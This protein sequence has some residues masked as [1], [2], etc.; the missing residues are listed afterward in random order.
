MA[1]AD[2]DLVPRPGLPRAVEALLAAAGLV[3]VLPI[4]AVAALAIVL[5]SA[6]SPLF[7]QERV[8]RE[9]RHFRL[10]KLRT[11]RKG[12]GPEV[13][14][15][16]DSRITRV[17][18]VLRLLKVDE[19]PQLWN[20]LVGDMSFVGPRPEVP[21]L[22]D[23]SNDLWKHVL[24]VRPGITDPVTLALRDE[25][26]L[27]ASV[28]GDRELFYRE[29][30]QPFKLRGYLDYMEKRTILTDL[31]VI[32]RTALAAAHVLRAPAVNRAQ[33]ESEEERNSCP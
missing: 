21:A 16:G 20:V 18:R 5:D 4:L 15:S 28:Q 17:G 3:I 33:L 11:M 22:V 31:Q 10:W 19:L 25:E 6:G 32:L 29:V 1:S 14:V 27:L 2:P 24:A 23:G 13:T 30:L 26:A 9:G 8:G 12:D 7:L